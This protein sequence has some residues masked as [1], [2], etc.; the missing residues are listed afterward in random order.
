MWI[1]A[2]VGVVGKLVVSPVFE[3]PHSAPIDAGQ[4]PRAFPPLSLVGRLSVPLSSPCW[5]C[6]L[7]DE[8]ELECEHYSVVRSFNPHSALAEGRT[9]DFRAR[10]Y[11]PKRQSMLRRYE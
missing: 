5:R 4:R 8:L 6:L 10:H 3:R 7:C 9:G 2:P 11:R 1:L